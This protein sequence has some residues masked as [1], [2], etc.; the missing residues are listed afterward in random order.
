LIHANILE[1]KPVEGGSVQELRGDVLFKKG[2]M[3][4]SCQKA[5][6]NETTGIA[7]MTGNTTVVKKDLKLTCDSLLFYS[8]EDLLKNFDNVHIWD[9]DY[10]LTADS[11]IYLTELDSGYANGN[12]TLIQ[13]KQTIFADALQYH[14]KPGSDAVSYEA[15][16]NVVIEEG[17]RIAICG[18]ALYNRD[19]GKTVLKINPEITDSGRHLSGTEIALHYEN[20]KL[21]T[22]FI[23][24]KAHM[25]SP[26][27]GWRQTVRD[28]LV[29]RDSV[30]TVNDLQGKTLKGYFV[31]GELDSLRL[32]GMATSLY[33]VFEDS[34]YK[35]VNEASGDT[36]T[37]LFDKNDMENIL[38]EGGAQGTFTPDSTNQKTE[39]PINYTAKKIKYLTEEELTHLEKNASII[40]QD[41]N[42]TA[43]YMKLNMKSNI[44]NALPIIPNDT[45]EIPI[46]PTVE[47]KGKEPMKGDEILYNLENKKGRIIMGETKMEDGFYYGNEIRNRGDDTYYIQESIYTTCDLPIP[48]FHFA[49]D[50]MKMISE[51]KVV[52]RPL[53][54][55]VGGIPIFGIP[56]AIFPHQHGDRHSGWIMPT[57]GETTRRGQFI[58]GLGYYW[59][60]N[61]FWDSKVLLNFAD[62]QG[63]TIKL[64]NMY[65]KRYSYGGSLGIETRYLLSSQNDITQ[66]GDDN[67]TDIVLN[68]SHNQIMRNNQ[69]LNVR[70]SYYSNGEYNRDT[71][72]DPTV[73]LKQQAVSN[74][75]YSKQWKKWKNSL[76]L[77]LSS[78]RDLMA[79]DKIDSNSVFYQK[80]YKAGQ[81]I[82]ITNN[83]LPSMSFRHGQSQ[84]FPEKSTLKRWYN[85]ISWTYSSNF[86]NKMRTNFESD[87]L[88]QTDSTYSF[89]W[90]MDGSDGIIKT[91]SNPVATHN[92]SLTAPQKIFKYIS[93]NPSISLKHVW[94]NKTFDAQLNPST[95]SLTSIEKQ[96]FATRTTGSFRLSL[97]TQLYGMF[98]VKIAGLKGIRHVASPS[99]GY[100][101]TPDFSDPLFGYDFKY[102]QEIPDT[103]GHIL[104]HDRFKG[105]P[106]GSTSKSK[107]QRMSFSLNNVFQAKVGEEE[108]EKK[109]DLF[110]WKMS[111][112]YNFVADSLKLANLRSSVR[113]K[114]GKKLNLDLSMTHDFYKIREQNSQFKRVNKLNRLPRL[115]NARISTGFR[116]SGKFMDG[117]KQDEDGTETDTLELDELE[118]SST[119]KGLIPSNFSNVNSGNLWSTSL[120]LS[121]SLNKSNPLNHR[122]TFWVNTNSD[123][124][125]TPNWK[126]KYSA[127]FDVLGKEL[128]SHSFSIYRDLHCW[129]LSL[130]WTPSGFGQGVYL[131]INVKS[132]TL[133]DLKIEQKSGLYGRR[134][135]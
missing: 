118:L 70:A 78:T 80:P 30:E 133:R 36:I 128:V 117:R 72:L 111:T 17:T 112:S 95:N 18:Y 46:R 131:K 69:K 16:G 21:E 39:A 59:A 38:I 103:S 4:L 124:Q 11:V 99:I 22:L 71:G 120:N 122:E 8:Q 57:Y 35:G 6:F 130:N 48:H 107:S 3:E 12:A 98:P 84:L 121:Y 82:N 132:P 26:Q 2:E 92:F 90:K 88:W 53:I 91:E 126:V 47:E 97:R 86:N 113:T 50:K 55:Y 83:T 60:P 1:N 93:M 134:A 129:E 74:A 76:S 19:E 108:D 49:S 62:R 75:T 63:L 100:S 85:N 115:I 37:M 33:H 127:R 51:D 79:D 7:T 67:K 116:F 14:K 105:T 94:V 44:L 34:I 119:G 102:F 58:D 68:W 61:P 9:N 87:T 27:F 110:S 64:S 89:Q 23:P 13:Q 42:L 5:L 28:T 65:K 32:E 109:I 41:M 52:A 40:H 114:L 135:F 24:A 73:R 20:E 31:N 104:F 81:K 45:T 29:Q 43:G 54:L 15:V 96:G 25:V 77:N 123:I 101:Y 106:A 10:D 66:I 56:F 125:V